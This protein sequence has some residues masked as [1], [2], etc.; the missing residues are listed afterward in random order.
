MPPGYSPRMQGMQFPSIT[1][2][3]Y[4]AVEQAYIQWTVAPSST[5]GFVQIAIDASIAR[6]TELLAS[7]TSWVSSQP[8][9]SLDNVSGVQP[10]LASSILI[11]GQP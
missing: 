9:T 10:D 2:P 5:T 3:A 4:A 8:T 11:L 1:V 6:N 7:T